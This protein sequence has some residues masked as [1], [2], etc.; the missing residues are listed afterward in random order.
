MRHE[1]LIWSWPGTVGGF[2]CGWVGLANGRKELVV[3]A[4]VSDVKLC[5]AMAGKAI[6]VL[7]SGGWC[8]A[9]GAAVWLVGACWLLHIWHTLGLGI[10]FSM[11]FESN[12]S[13]VSVFCISVLRSSEFVLG[14]IIAGA[15][16]HT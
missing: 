6:L 2:E 15:R 8:R 13:F 5:Y 1:G 4:V 12:L 16:R 10:L 7:A 11:L 14:D 9:E 3:C